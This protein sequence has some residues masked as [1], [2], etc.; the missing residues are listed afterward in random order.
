[1]SLWETMMEGAVT[2]LWV[3][4]LTHSGSAHPQ[5]VCSLTVQCLCSP[6]IVQGR[7]WEGACSR[8]VE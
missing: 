2:E 1:M 7:G 8:T 5:W 6:I 3:G 4:L